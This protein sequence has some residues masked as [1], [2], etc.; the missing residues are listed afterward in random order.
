MVT[1]FSI[2]G[3][4]AVSMIECRS[5]TIDHDGFCVDEGRFVRGEEDRRHGDL[6]SG[7]PM[8]CG[9]CRRSALAR[10][11]TGLSKPAQ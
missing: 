1:F 11:A 5:S 6:S 4:L 8:P 3:D 10:S 9:G 2:S 7:V